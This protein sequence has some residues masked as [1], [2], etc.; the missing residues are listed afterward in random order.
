MQKILEILKSLK[1]DFEGVLVALKAGDNADAI[2]KCVNV[3]S[4]LK[5]AEDEA[6]TLEDKP[7]DQ[8]AGDAP[9]GDTPAD[10]GDDKPAGDENPTAEDLEK[11]K[12]MQVE[13]AKRVNLG[14]SADTMEA[15]IKDVKTLMEVLNGAG[16][17][18]VL[19][20]VI[21]QSKTNTETI[22]KISKKVAIS[23]QVGDDEEEKPVQKSR[24]NF[25][26]QLK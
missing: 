9:A 24:Y 2:E 7:A 4:V 3:V 12:A 1:T 25:G 22:D 18:Q 23:K 13:I 16:G 15:V 17:I 5:N 21:E 10:G 26:S 11:T 14:I 20:E 19:K 8:P 6:K